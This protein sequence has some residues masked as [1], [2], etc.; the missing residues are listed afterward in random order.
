MIVNRLSI[1]S[2]NNSGRYSTKR[3]S[4]QI[5][6]TGGYIYNKSEGPA[7]KTGRGIASFILY[8]YVGA[9]DMSSKDN[10]NTGRLL[11]APKY[12]RVNGQLPQ[13]CISDGTRPPKP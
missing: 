10:K 8:N 9:Y 11:W 2:K 3:Q 6:E 4:R 12:V 13:A 1:K 7:A 5:S